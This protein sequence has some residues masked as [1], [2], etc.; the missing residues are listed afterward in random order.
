MRIYNNKY[1]QD[2]SMGEVGD[3]NGGLGYWLDEYPDMRDIK[4]GVG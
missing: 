3:G 4:R 1:M 2:D